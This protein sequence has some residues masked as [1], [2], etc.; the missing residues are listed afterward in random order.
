MNTVIGPGRYYVLSKVSVM[1]I[2]GKVKY[3]LECPA[4]LEIG[5]LRDKAGRGG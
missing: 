4:G 2:L 3:K 1:H 5:P